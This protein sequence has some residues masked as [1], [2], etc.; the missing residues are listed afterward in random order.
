MK[1]KIRDKVVVGTG[2]N[3]RVLEVYE[4]TSAD[5]SKYLAL[6]G[7]WNEDRKQFDEYNGA[8]SLYEEGFWGGIQQ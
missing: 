1:Y 4:E 7:R 8:L 2:S 5:G 6:R 3:Q